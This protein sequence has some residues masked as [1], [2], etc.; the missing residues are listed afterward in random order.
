MNYRLLC[1]P[2]CDLSPIGD[3]ITAERIEVVTLEGPADLTVGDR[4]SVLLL[5]SQGPE[6]L[7]EDE[8]RRFVNDGGAIVSLGAD[9]DDDVPGTVPDSLLSGFVSA[10]LTTR[11]ILI[12][13]RAGYRDAAGRAE[14][15]RLR[16]ET[17]TRT[18]ELSEM[19][20][21]GMALATERDYHALLELILSQARQLTGADAGSLYLVEGEEGEERQLRFKLAQ[22]DS[23]PEI[24]FVEFTIAIDPT[25][26]AGY[27][28]STNEPLVIDD[29]YFLPPDVEYSINRSFDEKHGYRTRSMLTIPMTDHHGQVIGILQLINRKRHFDRM[30][31]TPE[32]F[33]RE[34]TPFSPRTVEL[35]RALAGQAAVSIEN[36][37]LYE[38]IERLFEGFVTA[39]V[40]AIEQR[41]PTTFGHSGR[42]A[43]MTVTLAQETD[44]IRAGPYRSLTF[45]REQLRELRYAGLLHDF[46]K[47]GVREQVLVKAKKLYETDLALIKQRFAF[48]YRTAERDFHSQRAE[49]LE[50]HGPE[51]YE[52]YLERLTAEYN[53]RIERLDQFLQLVVESNEPTVL[54]EGN[55]DHLLRYADEYYT[56]LEG[57]PQPYLSQDEVRY[58]TIRKGSLDESER[59]EIESHVNHTYRF[60]QEI[61]WTRALRDIPRIA[62]GHHEKLNGRGYP[63]GV[64]DEEIPPQT[65]MMT[66]ADIFDALTASDRPYKRALPPERALGIMDEEVRAGMLDPDLFEVFTATRAYERPAG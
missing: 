43:T 49:Y 46:G 59:Q 60:L 38:D 2:D 3:A 58:L 19:T 26:I 1:H 50:A 48:I 23:R 41:D 31:E 62:Y 47:V 52:A 57:N 9:D 20:A 29:A 54:P 44:R 21:I 12:A 28:A 61:P 6:S 14:T 4:P 13:L 11:K 65:R 25:S 56:D 24:P 42:V 27:V 64:H 53:A 66:I 33:E 36:S 35:V 16:R 22:N 15:Q 32:D 63:R 10:P 45:T 30:L 17:A 34:I 40:T 51:G 18:R 5:D 7:T 8:L 55:F 39:A 37:Q